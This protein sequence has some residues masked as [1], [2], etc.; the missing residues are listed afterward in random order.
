MRDRQLQKTQQ[1]KLRTVQ[2]ELITEM[3]VS[4]GTIKQKTQLTVQYTGDRWPRN[5]TRQSRVGSTTQTKLG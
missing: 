3:C 4:T 2:N 5:T 1:Q